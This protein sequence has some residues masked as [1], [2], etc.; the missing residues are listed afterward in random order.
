M[1]PGFAVAV[2][3][4]LMGLE[5][6]RAS[7]A[8]PADAA[9]SAVISAGWRRWGPAFPGQVDGIFALVVIE[10]DQAWF[11]RDPSG[12]ATLYV[13]H[14]D[15]DRVTFGTQIDAV[16]TQ[17]RTVRSLSMPSIHEYLRFLDIAAPNTVFAD[18]LAPEAGRLLR[19]GATG[20]RPVSPVQPKAQQVGASF[21]AAVD[22]LDQLLSASVE[23]RLEA[24]TRPAVFLSGGVDS[25]LLCAVAARRRPD[26]EAVTVGFEPGPFDEA[27]VAARIAAHLGVRHRVLRFS[28]EDYLGAFDRLMA[29]LEQPMAD[30]ATMSTVLAFED[31]AAQ[32]DVV[33]D[34]TGADEAVGAMPARHVRLAVQYASLIPA[35]TRAALVR[36]LRSWPALARHAPLLDFEHPADLMI[37]WQGFTRKEI[38]ALCMAPVSFAHT[39]FYDVFSRFARGAHYARY[40]ALLNA[41]PCDRLSQA[42]LLTGLRP[43]YPFAQRQVDGYLRQL[44][45]DYLHLPG[46][47]KRILRA[48]LARYVPRELWDVPK[49]GFDFPLHDFLVGDEHALVRRFLGASRWQRSGLLAPGRVADLAQRFITGERGLRFRVWGLVVLMAWIENHLAEGH[50]MKST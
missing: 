50:P 48:L 30:P 10:G 26:I 41:M 25:A 38:E 37:R 20:T 44:R 46:A 7:L 29:G 13:H 35:R 19:W 23:A 24:A 40:S 8:L 12:L 1:A 47:P 27:P 2:H 45:T 39:H 34:G 6:L 5:A 33:L 11:Y 49:H 3:G 18:V 31:C 22:R 42:T 21:E 36:V 17:P 14:A 4:D 43:R 16:L 28:R 32:Y 9:P 15:R